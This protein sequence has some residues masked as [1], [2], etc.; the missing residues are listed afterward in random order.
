MQPDMEYLF[1]SGYAE[2][3]FAVE[4]KWRSSFIAG[5]IQWAKDYQLDNYRKFSAE[6][7]MNVFIMLGVGGAPG[8]PQHLYIIPLNEISSLFLSQSQ[9]QKYYRHGKGNFFFE[10]DTLSLK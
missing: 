8:N 5:E 6:R 2:G 10:P 1:K 3:K 7:N 4:C 9:M